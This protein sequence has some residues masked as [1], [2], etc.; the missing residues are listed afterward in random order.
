M[1]TSLVEFRDDGFWVRDGQL[2]VWL[3]LLV[4]QIE[5]LSDPPP[6]L[7]DVHDD[8]QLQATA[9][10]HGF[11]SA[12]LDDIITSDDRGD[13][14]LALSERA[15]NWLRGHGTTINKDE[16]NVMHTG[17]EEFY[18]TDDVQ[19]SIFTDAGEH[20]VLLLRGELPDRIDPHIAVSK[21]LL[22]KEP[23]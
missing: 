3:Y 15:L 11:V 19:T 16:L 4:R 2:E 17:G 1:G 7:R 5:A 6:W 23:N 13:L 20:F 12:H 9:G 22:K 10:F 21:Q 18:W 14:I 8:W